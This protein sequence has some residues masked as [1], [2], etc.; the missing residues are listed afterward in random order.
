M[1]VGI[2]TQYYPPEMG[3]P[4]ARLSNLAGHLAERGHE[5]HILTAM[6]NYPRGRVYPGYGGFVRRERSGGVSI[7]RSYIYAATGIGWRRIL[8][9]FS[10]VL[11]SALLGTFTLPRL[12]YLITESPPLFLG[13]SGY[14]LSRLKGA[15][16]VFNVS[17]LWLDSAVQLGALKE[18]RT[19]RIARSLE[20]FFY[21]K[22][23]CV[24]GQSKEI[25]SEIGRL[26]PEA[27]LYHLTNGVA[28]DQFHPGGRS[29]DIRAELGPQG[30]IIALYA[31][32]HGYAQGLGQLLDAAGMLRDLHALSIVLIGDGPEKQALMDRA[33]AEGLDNVR[34]LDA[35]PRERIPALLASADMALVPL[36][37]R[38]FG[39][40]PSKLYE[41]MGVG[42]PVVLMTGGEAEDIVVDSGAGVVVPPG[43]VNGL[44]SAIRRLT[45][46]PEER[47]AMGIR[48]R[49]AAVS[50]FDRKAIAD[51]FIDFLEKQKSC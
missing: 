48:G 25:L 40:V 18:G 3:A 43:N 41:A 6:P 46:D 26:H 34:F 38:L 27:T 32:L 9:Y 16:W 21:R 8:N 36:K 15:R 42:L 31:G 37:E 44:A 1:R 47:R 35:A 2:L 22:A 33:R 45:N 24:A 5:V 49:E 30:S 23:W 14:F 12:D 13:I 10:F 20:S 11:S 50:R 17:D 29:D 19:L 4:Q 51:E 28:S 7:V 39:A